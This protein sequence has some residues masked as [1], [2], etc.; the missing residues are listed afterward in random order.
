VATIKDS[1]A[2]LR[3]AERDSSLA[4]QSVVVWLIVCLAGY[5]DPRWPNG[6]PDA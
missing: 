6:F 1:W 3:I 5:T 2:N 4:A